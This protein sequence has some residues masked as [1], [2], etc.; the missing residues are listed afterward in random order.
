[1]PA[2]Q[3][4]TGTTL[5]LD[6]LVQLHNHNNRFLSQVVVEVRADVGASVQMRGCELMQE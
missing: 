5:T 4:V 2:N 1:M 6:L 3:V